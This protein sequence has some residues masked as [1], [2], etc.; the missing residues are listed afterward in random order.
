MLMDN[1]SIHGQA[2]LDLSDHLGNSVEG[3]L[4]R[5]YDAAQ[6]LNCSR[7]R[8]PKMASR[9]RK[10]Q[11]EIDGQASESGL[12]KPRDRRQGPSRGGCKPFDPCVTNKMLHVGR[13]RILFQMEDERELGQRDWKRG[14]AHCQKSKVKAPPNAC[15]ELDYACSAL[16]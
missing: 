15:L 12:V 13:N 11:V 9:E 16:V 5:A 6:R 3:R 2:Y 8:R 7:R 14:A 10:E 4:L 1:C